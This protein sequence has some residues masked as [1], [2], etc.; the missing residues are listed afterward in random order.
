[1]C[2]VFAD[3][4]VH[5][6]KFCPAPIPADYPNAWVLTL[7][8]RDGGTHTCGAG[9]SGAPQVK[10]NAVSRSDSSGTVCRALHV[11]GQAGSAPESHSEGQ[12]LSPGQT[13]PLSLFLFLVSSPIPVH[14]VSVSSPCQHPSPASLSLICLSLVSTSELISCSCLSFSTCLRLL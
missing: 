7:S 14:G 5:P 2:E 4:Q 12:G 13:D 11:T 8:P 9:S 3:R 6:N 1:M 10:R